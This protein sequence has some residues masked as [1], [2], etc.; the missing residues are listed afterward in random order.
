MRANPVITRKFRYM[1]QC[2]GKHLQNRSDDH[3]SMTPM[4]SGTPLWTQ[5]QA[6]RLAWPFLQW[7][8]P[9]SVQPFPLCSFLSPSPPHSQHTNCMHTSLVAS[10][11]RL[12]SAFHPSCVWDACCKSEDQGH[13]NLIGAWGQRVGDPARS[14]GHNILLQR[15][16]SVAGWVLCKTGGLP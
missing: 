4:S 13:S 5:L 8:S 6:A 12:S 3:P 15:Q 9:T 2:C 7:P 1:I 10:Y 14:S 11:A 16:R